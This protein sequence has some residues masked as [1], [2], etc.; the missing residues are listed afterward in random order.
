MTQSEKQKALEDLSKCKYG[1]DFGDWLDDYLPLI[2]SLLTDERRDWRPIESAPR[3]GT[4]IL[5]ADIKFRYRAIL[6][7]S[8]REW[9]EVDRQGQN[10]GIGFYPTHWEPLLPLPTTADDLKGE[11]YE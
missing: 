9:E 4:L 1:S 11:N 7:F 10:L 8:G 5:G 3:D 2:K 6:R